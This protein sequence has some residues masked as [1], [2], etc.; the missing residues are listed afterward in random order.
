[1]HSTW[2]QFLFMRKTDRFP[3][4]FSLSSETKYCTIRNKYSMVIQRNRARSIRTSY[5]PG[6]LSTTVSRRSVHP[7]TD[8]IWDPVGPYNLVRAGWDSPF[9]LSALSVR[10]GSE[11]SP[12]FARVRYWVQGKCTT[13]CSRHFLLYIPGTA[14]CVTAKSFGIIRQKRAIYLYHKIICGHEYS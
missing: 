14:S 6:W 3:P 12:S 13:D 1:M 11:V 9:S 8:R 4:V 5:F 7:S 2:T 10:V